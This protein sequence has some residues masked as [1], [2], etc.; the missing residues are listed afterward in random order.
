MAHDLSDDPAALELAAAVAGSAIGEYE[1][2]DGAHIELLNVSE[3]ATYLVR[4]KGTAPK[5]MRVHRQDYHTEV[6]IASELAWATALSA[7]EGV[8]TPSALPNRHGRC[9]TNVVDGAGHLRHCVLFDFIDGVE[10]DP[11]DATEG[12]VLL[13]E[14]T[15]RMHR[16]AREWRRPSWFRRFRWDFDAAF[17][18]EV[19]W[20]S[21][22]NGIGVG[23]EEVGVLSR[24]EER[25]ADRLHAFGMGPERFGL[26]H[27]DMRLAN[28]LWKSPG[29]VAV[30]DFDDCGF[31][32]FLY[33]LGTS[34]SFIEDHPQ[35]PALVD[36]WL[37]GYR[38]VAH[39]PQDDEAEIWTFILFRRLLLLA[40]IGSHQ[41]ADIARE[42]GPVYAKGTC[43][44]A[45]RYLTDNGARSRPW[46]RAK[47]ER[48]PDWWA[49]L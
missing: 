2:M 42:L 17:G 25:L 24:L 34:L 33:D 38:S 40:W 22:R 5:V 36:A 8:H 45:E 6:E 20:G 26:V 31:S 12:F 30:I 3:N 11:E 47:P 29:Q 7:Q 37:R 46:P 13:G 16:H 9:V 21:W 23:V 41:A 10:A 4:P 27:A 1:A 44:L 32:W 39:L 28:L 18:R 15:A 49:G 35:V 48:L 19:R 14:L 43:D